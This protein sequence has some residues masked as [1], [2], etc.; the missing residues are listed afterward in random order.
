MVHAWDRRGLIPNLRHHLESDCAVVGIITSTEYQPFLEEVWNLL[1]DDMVA[2][3]VSQLA[4]TYP[5]LERLR[6]LAQRW[7]FQALINSMGKL[8]EEGI[9]KSIRE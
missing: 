1:K 5:L 3:Q 9:R 2:G 4:E 8:Y 6:R 7:T